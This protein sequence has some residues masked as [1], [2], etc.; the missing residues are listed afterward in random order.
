M[1]QLTILLLFL[2]SA[3]MSAQSPDYRNR[4][5]SDDARV[6]ALLGELT[7]DEKI[8]LLSTD[9]GVERLGIPHC[10]QY[11]G[12]HGLALGGPGMWGKRV[13]NAD[14]TAGQI[15][16][17][18]TIFPQSYGLGES[19]D[20]KLMRRIG[21]QEAEEIRWYFQSGGSHNPSLVVRSPNSDLARDPRWGRT[22]ESFGED[23]Y[24]VAQM[25]VGMVRGLQG[26]NPR[27][28][29]SAALMKHFLANSNENGRDSSSSDFDERLFREY[30]SYPFWKGITVGGSRAFMASYNAWNGITMCVNPVLRDIARREWGNNGIICTDGG[31]LGLLVNA[32]KA[33]PSMEKGAAATVK[34]TTGQFLDNYEEHVRKA[35]ADG[36]LTEHDIDE[37]I[38]GNIFVALKLGLLDGDNTANPY[39]H[40]GRDTTAV[41][42]WNTNG[43]KA[44]AR[45]AVSKSVVLLKNDPGKRLLPLDKSRIHRIAIIGSLAD[46]LYQDW[47]SGCPPYQVTIGQAFDE[48]AMKNNAEVFHIGD[49]YMCDQLLQW[50]QNADIVF[51]CVGNHPVGGDHLGWKEVS[52]HDYGREAVDRETMSLPEESLVR[53]VMSV[54][55]NTVLVLVSSFPYTINWSQRHVPSILHLTHGGQ[56]TGH[57]L[58]D[59]VTGKV[60]PAG[61]TTQTWVSRV[62]D[63]PDMMDYDIRHGRTYMYNEKPV[64]YPFGYGLSYTTFKYE[65]MK[66]EQT[67]NGDFIVRVR[68]RNDGK[69]DG[70]EV[71]QLYASYPYS[72]VSHP[73]LQLVGFLRV[74]I[75]A[76]V[77]KEVEL[78]VSQSDLCYWDTASHQ[79]KVEPGRV[80]LH[81]GGSSASLPLQ[82]PIKIR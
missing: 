42:P 77:S 33:Y 11:E 13:R 62:D 63:L 61:R 71:V 79:W 82:L 14:G 36:L 68:V 23:P 40:I 25:T 10:G 15:E 24:L 57:G 65:A 17:P 49:G 41:E 32:H 29:K 45:E 8:H 60:N 12:L 44:L 76:G 35:L 75:P 53:K 78:T 21:N 66:A 5:L 80:L 81:C 7:L 20:V 46:T 64:L 30:Y 2:F 59:V 54:N 3:S 9:L 56:E 52:R 18:S 50:I 34:A 1:R 39:V 37:A 72:K 6:E 19:W 55:P 74:N 31:A 38:R 48:W 51:V 67:K 73:R 4:S 43:A 22:E 69:A 70:E 16:Y 58:I 47:Y 26:D 28:W 27:Y